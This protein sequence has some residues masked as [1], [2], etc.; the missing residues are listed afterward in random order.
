MADIPPPAAPLARLRDVMRADRLDALLVCDGNPFLN[1]GVAAEDRRLGWLTGFGGGTG[2]LAVTPE[3]T[4]LFTARLYF[5]QARLE[6]ADAGETVEI[7]DFFTDELPSWLRRHCPAGGRIGLDASR[8][9][10]GWVDRLRQALSAGNRRLVDLGGNPVDRLRPAGADP[11]GAA[12]PHDPAHAGEASAAKRRRIAALV[13]ERGADAICLHN[14]ASVAWLFNI[15]ATGLPRTPFLEAAAI[16]RR[17]GSAILHCDTGRVPPSVREALGDGVTLRPWADLPA[18]LRDLAAVSPRVMVD[19][20][21]TNAAAFAALLAAGIEPVLGRDPCLD[22]RAIKNAVERA[23]M[24]AAYMADSRVILRA[25]HWLDGRMAARE[26]TTEFDVAAWMR[27]QRRKDPLHLEDMD[28]NLVA[29]GPNAALPH[30]HPELE[31]ALPLL[32]RHLALID[33]GGQYLT[34]TTDLT[35][36]VALHDAVPETLKRVYTQCLKAHA[37]W[38]TTPFPAGANGHQIDAIA[39]AMLWRA[40]YDYFH[41]TGHGIGCCGET[42]EGPMHLNMRRPNLTP[43]AAGMFIAAD[44]AMYVEGDYGIRLENGMEC[45]PHR[46]ADAPADAFAGD[47]LAFDIVSFVPYDRRLI[48]RDLLTAEERGW[49]DAYHA[50]VLACHADALDPGERDWLARMCAPI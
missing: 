43:L 50:R 18:S 32:G 3:R 13:A 16:L 22:A 1:E 20:D 19:P 6:M 48:L 4:A 35:R 8:H 15:R 26:P 9:A 10:H 36:T 29:T 24:R 23:G 49:L 38:T 34:G 2:V 45:V 14:L 28:F 17:D 42:H 11:R 12:F 25:L 39:R 40:G 33:S 47:W 44:S 41:G 27:E 7:G 37:F 30:Y 21:R 46:P 31:T 5:E